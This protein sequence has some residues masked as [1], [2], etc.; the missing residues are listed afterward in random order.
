[1]FDSFRKYFE[2]RKPTF[3]SLN[4]FPLKDKY[5]YR[6]ATWTWHSEKEISVFDPCG[7]R[8][9]TLDPWPQI[10]FLDAKGKLTVSEYVEYMASKY[11][12]QIPDK[13]DETIINQLNS[14]FN[15]KLIAYSDQEIILDST[16]DNPKNKP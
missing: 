4:E 3:D 5:F 16:V 14:L 2:R 7:P 13:L 8:V 11:T 6:T 1:M 10:V 12:S 15:I 9:I